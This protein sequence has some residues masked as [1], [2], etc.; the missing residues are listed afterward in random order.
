MGKIF[1]ANQI[2]IDQQKP[3]FIDHRQKIEKPEEDLAPAEDAFAV[4]TFR[5]LSP[6][7]LAGSGEKIITK[8][9]RPVE[10]ED[11]NAAPEK[12]FQPKPAEPVSFLS[13]TAKKAR[14]A[15][16]L[17]AIKI[18]ELELEALEEELRNW[19]EELKGKESS[20]TAQEQE[21]SQ[22]M[23]KK[24]QEADA[25]AAK[26]VKTAR[27]TAATIVETAKAESEAI[28]KA[29]HLEIDS[30]REK[31]YKEGYAMGEEKG[32]SAG[33]K[34]G[35]HEASLD[36][37]NLM[38]ESEAFV[39]ELQTSR[40]GILKAS[41]EE[42]LKLV[43]AFARTVIKVEPV[44]QPEIILKNIDQA[45]NRVSE[46]DKIVMRINI[47]DKAMC[48]AHKEQFMARLGSVTELRIIED[49]TLSPGG[50]KIETGVGTIDAT[51]ESQA[52]EL[53]RALLSKLRKKL[54]DT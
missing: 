19:E 42:M 40:M 32:I 31:A 53:E 2:K 39:N 12:P 41:E 16:A 51:I 13:P 24:R 10:E 43:I 8:P 25:E 50:I 38:Q 22:N 7:H 49:P 45:L 4:E 1:K 34:Q 5:A 36:W 18:R 20:L 9:P 3:V 6:E 27:E 28:K 15:A 30:V 33:E 52:R 26:T 35:L 21:F 11:S 48:Q 54:A 46:V 37:H 17:E 23:L 44:A 47:R 29:A 14:H